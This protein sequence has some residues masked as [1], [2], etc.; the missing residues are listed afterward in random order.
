MKFNIDFEVKNTNFGCKICHEEF[1]KIVFD[2]IKIMMKYKY[3]E[4]E[5]MNSTIDFAKI[6]PYIVKCP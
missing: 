6:C 1:D 5:L 3:E 4:A 2:P